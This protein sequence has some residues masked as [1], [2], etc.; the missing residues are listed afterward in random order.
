M[1]PKVIVMI[2]MLVLPGTGDSNVH[3][4]QFSDAQSC[5]R[6][7]DIEASDPFVRHVECAALN[8]GMLTLRFDTPKS[9]ESA[10]KP[11]MRRRSEFGKSVFN[12][13]G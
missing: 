9:G 11:A 5:I 8:D 2:T 6:A 1:E 7:A 13:A 10:T 3:V 12:P 4:R